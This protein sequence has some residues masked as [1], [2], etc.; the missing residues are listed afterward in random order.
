MLCQ[1]RSPRISRIK[2]LR[3]PHFSLWS[4]K[5]SALDHFAPIIPI[6]SFEVELHGRSKHCATFAMPT[7][8]VFF[9]FENLVE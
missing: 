8:I 4:S 3:S 7:R 5:A 9:F 2:L 1:N 6:C